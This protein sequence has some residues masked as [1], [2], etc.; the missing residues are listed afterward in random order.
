M[1]ITSKSNPKIKQVA[2]LKDKKFRKKSGAYVVEGFKMVSEAFACGKEIEL[3][4]GTEDAL[5]RFENQNVE[6]LAVSDSVLSFVSDAVT[7]QGILAVL[8]EDKKIVKSPDMPSV[9][10]DGVSDP[11]NMGT[12]IRTC[13]A[14]GVKDI[15]LVDCCD[16]FSP[17]AVRSSMSGIFFVNLYFLSREEISSVMQKTP[18]IVA[19][20]HGENVFTFNPPSVYCLVIGNEA[21]GV[22]EVVKNLAMHTVKIPMSDS[23]ES[24]NAGVSL[25]ITIYTLTEGKGKSLISNKYN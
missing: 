19:D 20:M 22:S 21:N 14:A 3:I 8:K 15:Y 17:K 1:I 24:L 7:P 18:I 23:V 4:V 12:I 16:P 6:K 25:A 5:K 11:G 13:V 2:M 9:L 10:L